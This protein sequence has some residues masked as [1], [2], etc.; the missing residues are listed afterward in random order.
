MSG[1]RCIVL[2]AASL[3]P[4]IAFAQPEPAAAGGRVD[5]IERA[6]RSRVGETIRIVNAHG[7]VRVRAVP[8][9]APASLRATVQSTGGE[10][11][12]RVDAGEH[13]R[14][15]VYAVA[16]TDA[17]ALLRVDVVLALPDRAGL[18]VRLER[19]DFTMHPARYP[20]RVRAQAGDVT[21]RTLGPVDA[22]VWSGHLVYNPPGG[23]APGGGRLQT[24][25]APVD[26]L[27]RNAGPLAFRVVSGAAVTT[28]SAALLQ[29]RSRDGRALLFGDH[30]DAAVLDIRTDHAPVRLVVEGHR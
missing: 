25:A 2:L 17:D 24:S 19:G 18:D 12:A 4:A 10:A 29:S 26:V 16:A 27:V 7:D 13:E 15:P 1:A 8:A 6:V 23:V 14:G 30:D 5:Q 11:A 20:V 22:R 28:D 21:L 3:A 9:G